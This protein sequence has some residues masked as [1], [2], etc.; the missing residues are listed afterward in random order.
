MAKHHEK[1]QSDQSLRCP[2]ENASGLSYPLS[3]Q[4]R[5]IRLADAHT[6]LSLHWVHNIFVGFIMSFNCI[7]LLNIEATYILNRLCSQ[8]PV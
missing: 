4:Q 5:L 1:T 3:A 2:H 6:D 8:S 7:A